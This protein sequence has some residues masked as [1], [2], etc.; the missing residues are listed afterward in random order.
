MQANISTMNLRISFISAK[1]KCYHLG[2]VMDIFKY[3]V[4][5][6]LTAWRFHLEQDFSNF[7]A[8]LGTLNKVFKMFS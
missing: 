6:S 7:K 1:F 8:V 4:Q 3:G 2:L 5:Q